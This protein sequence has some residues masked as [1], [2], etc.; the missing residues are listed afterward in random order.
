MILRLLTLAS[1]WFYTKMTNVL[2]AGLLSESYNLAM[3]TILITKASGQKEPFDR[4]KLLASLNRC[5]ATEKEA[6]QVLSH[7]EAEL[8]D[9]MTTDL[10]Y[11]HAY[12]VLK[13]LGNP[14]AFA[15]YSLRRA[16]SGLGP[17]GF[18]F[19]KFIAETMKKRGFTVETDQMVMGACVPHEVD[20]VA[21]N[22]DKLIMME[23]KFHNELGEKSDLK[24]ALYVKARF[25]DLRAVRHNYGKTRVLDEGWLVTNTK[26]STNAI[27]YGEC[28]GLKMVG[29]N[30]PK[31]GNLEHLIEESGL[32]P[33]TCLKSLTEKDASLLLERGMVLC[34]Q[35]LERPNELAEAGL[36]NRK[37]QEISAEAKVVCQPYL[38]AK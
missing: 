14:T 8:E 7:I 26:F 30:Y 35:I 33:I 5:K 32:H 28:A 12:S 2:V 18:P 31:K 34:T 9:G 19:E 10:I 27:T 29:W 13:K 36:D 4:N 37:V 38:L 25:D 24:V 21:H 16:L 20:V 15:K 23:V 6:Q 22:E 3:N 17:T 11:R 1:H